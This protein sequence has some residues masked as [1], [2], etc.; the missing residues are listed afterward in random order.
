MMAE[1]PCVIINVQRVGPSTGMPT[2]TEQGDLLQALFG[3]NGESPVAVLAQSTPSDG[4]DV[5]IEAFRIAVRHMIPVIVLSDGYLG[6][7]AEPWR[8][9]DIESL[10][11]IEVVHPAAGDTDRF[12]PYERDAD[13]LARPWAIPGTAGLEHR[14]GGLEKEN[15]T[16]D[17]SYDPANHQRMTDLRREKMEK[18]ADFYPP[19]EVDGDVEGDLLVLSWGS[20]FGAVRTAARR[21]RD[22]GRRVSH[23]HLRHVHPFPNDLREIIGRFRRLLVPELNDGQLLFLLRATYLVDAEGLNKVEGRPFKVAEV[24]SK[25]REMT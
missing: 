22:E 7:G 4:F 11:P 20:T 2:K 13:T 10:E 1:L 17:V 12:H 23:V 21:C 5:I 8:I 24:V 16:G 9:P 15:V 14:I 19:V 25:I 18:I 3:R 6:N